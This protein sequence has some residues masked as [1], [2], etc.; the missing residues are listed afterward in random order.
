MCGNFSVALF[1]RDGDEHV[2]DLLWRGGGEDFHELFV[3]ADFDPAAVIQSALPLICACQL[4][5]RRQICEPS[6]SREVQVATPTYRSQTLRRRRDGQMLSRGQEGQ[7]KGNRDHAHCGAAEQQDSRGAAK[8]ALSDNTSALWSAAFR[9][10][11]LRRR[12]HD[13]RI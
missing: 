12:R 6:E 13:A 4:C 1:L 2:Q 5:F 11:L 8:S 10:L 3:Y 7:G 9:K